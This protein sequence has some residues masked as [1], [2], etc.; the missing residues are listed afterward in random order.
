MNNSLEFFLNLTVFTFNNVPLERSYFKYMMRYGVIR[1][2][3]NTKALLFCKS[4]TPVSLITISVTQ[5]V[6]TC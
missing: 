2:N 5:P 1:L 4:V 3:R 6:I